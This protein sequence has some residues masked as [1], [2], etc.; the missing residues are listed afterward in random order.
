MRTEEFVASLP[1]GPLLRHVEQVHALVAHIAACERARIPTDQAWLALEHSLREIA[2]Y[3]REP[4]RYFIPPDIPE[5][6]LDVQAVMTSAAETFRKAFK[7]V[8]KIE[9]F[10]T[11]PESRERASE[12]K[13]R[14]AVR[15]ERQAGLRFVKAEATRVRTELGLTEDRS[16]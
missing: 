1:R 8:K 12:Y 9:P 10:K 2:V 13:Y 15:R 3:S 16:K 7:D 11:S 14:E 6:K 5:M 4:E